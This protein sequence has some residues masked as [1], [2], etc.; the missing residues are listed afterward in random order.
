[1][2]EKY[3]TSILIVS[4]SSNSEPTKEEMVEIMKRHKGHV[5]V[6]PIDYTY[7]FGNQKVAKTHRQKVQEYLFV[8][9]GLG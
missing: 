6:V 2:F 4:Y 7:S 9:Y 1:M 5:E 3:R 8:G